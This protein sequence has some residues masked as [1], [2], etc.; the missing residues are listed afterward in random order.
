[1][2]GGKEYPT[3]IH[4]TPK[5][6]DF[7]EIDNPV[8]F[9]KLRGESP[10]FSDKG[11]GRFFFQRDG[12]SYHFVDRWSG[13]TSYAEIQTL[14]EKG[15]YGNLIDK[16]L[17]NVFAGVHEGIWGKRKMWPSVAGDF[18]NQLDDDQRTK[19]N[20]PMVSGHQVHFRPMW[21]LKMGFENFSAAEKFCSTG[22]LSMNHLQDGESNGFESPFH[23]YLALV[24]SIKESEKVGEEITISGPI[25]STMIKWDLNREGAEILHGKDF[26]DTE[27]AHFA[28]KH[29]LN[30]QAEIEEFHALDARD[31][32]DYERLKGAVSGEWKSADDFRAAEQL[33]TAARGHGPRRNAQRP[34][35]QPT[36]RDPFVHDSEKFV[37]SADDY[38]L[39][40]EIKDDWPLTSP[41][42]PPNHG[43]RR[44]NP[45]IPQGTIN[46]MKKDNPDNLLVSSEYQTGQ[47]QAHYETIMNMSASSF[48]L[49]KENTRVMRTY[50]LDYL[51][52]AELVRRVID[53]NPIHITELLK[54]T[55]LGSEPEFRPPAPR[56]TGIPPAMQ[57]IWL[58]ITFNYNLGVE[59]TPA[60]ET[61]GKWWKSI[62]VAPSIDQ[63]VHFVYHDKKFRD[64]TIIDLDNYT[65]GMK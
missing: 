61:Q 20:Y 53:A 59:D 8:D 4:G 26:S 29:Q 54:D 36:P 49:Q 15:L 60:P 9:E 38:Y 45:P 24:L 34:H 47:G 35:I 39:W 32:E 18:L 64:I 30:S 13:L 6:D 46:Q 33:S 25:A 23:Y 10:L 37:F 55:S 62:L 63:L 3:P 12:V 43:H 27:S 50:S 17:Q 31:A 5:F 1:M 57:R 44:P 14:A 58:D 21:L 2:A 52:Q 51:W 19:E 28:L 11:E 65:V 7:T 41:P 48:I 42:P 56:N 40:L 22:Y 16:R